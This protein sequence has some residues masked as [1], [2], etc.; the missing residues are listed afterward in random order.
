MWPRSGAAGSGPCCGGRTARRRPGHAVVVLQVE[1]ERRPQVVGEAVDRAGPDAGGPLGIVGQ[2]G[3]VRLDV[4][5][6][7]EATRAAQTPP[8]PKRPHRL[9]VRDRQRSRRGGRRAGAAVR[10]TPGGGRR[11]S[12]PGRGLRG[13]GRLH[14]YADVEAYDA[15]LADDP[16]R[17]ARVRAR[18]IDRLPTTCGRRSR[19]TWSTTTAWPNPG[20][21]ALRPPQ[22]GPPIGAAPDRGHLR[23]RPEPRRGSHALPDR[24]ALGPHG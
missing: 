9:T 5:V 12:S 7:V 13:P 10:S 24:P 1:R 23:P 3:V 20:A 4:G 11:A 8:Q 2:E 17:A 16:E 14:R 21:R 22:H 6:P 19:S 18:T 15:L